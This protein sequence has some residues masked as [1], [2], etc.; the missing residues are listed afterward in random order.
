MD[1]LKILLVDDSPGFLEAADGFLSRQPLMEIVGRA[2]SG[3]EAIRLVKQ[4]PLDF[5]LMDLSMPD[6]SGLEATQRIKAL[7]FPPR[8]IMVTL[9]DNVA[10]R[11]AALEA[12]AE[13]FVSK[14][15]FV[16]VVL[17]LIY[18]LLTPAREEVVD[19]VA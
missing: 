18:Q 5:V 16:E 3:S 13:G 9:H 11:R 19:E 10:Y 12:G 6:M 2:C 7:P 8:V 1:K 4:L 14:Q 15:E 17:P